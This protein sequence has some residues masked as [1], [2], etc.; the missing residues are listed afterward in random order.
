MVRVPIVMKASAAAIDA[1]C[2]D[3]TLRSARD[4]VN[5]FAKKFFS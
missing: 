3:Q 4:L 1:C 5:R 2:E